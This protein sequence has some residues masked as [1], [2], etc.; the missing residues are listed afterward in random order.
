MVNHPNRSKRAATH[1]LVVCERD[2]LTGSNNRMSSSKGGASWSF[3]FRCPVCAREGRFNTNYLGS[4]RRV[5]CDGVRFT[6]RHY[7][8]ALAVAEAKRR[9]EL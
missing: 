2:P 1:D 3:V 9:G 6:T 7:D 4:E 8:L 5:V